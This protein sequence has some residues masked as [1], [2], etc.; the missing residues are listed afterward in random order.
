VLT[1]QIA[2]DTPGKI[3]RDTPSAEDSVTYCQPVLPVVARPTLHAVGQQAPVVLHVSQGK[4]VRAA[5]PLTTT[6]HQRTRS[7]Q[8]HCDCPVFRM[9]WKAVVGRATQGIKVMACPTAP[10]SA[11]ARSVQDAMRNRGWPRVPR[12]PKSRLARQLM[13]AAAIVHGAHDVLHQPAAAHVQRSPPAH[14]F[15]SRA[16]PRCAA[17]PLNRCRRTTDTPRSVEQGVLGDVLQG[18]E[19]PKPALPV[20]D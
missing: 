15:R 7:L 16:A 13:F 17:R 2:R 8:Q 19:A 1:A 11:G 9:S 20:H 6:S 5:A 14:P 3:T 12:S 10:S 18:S 4:A